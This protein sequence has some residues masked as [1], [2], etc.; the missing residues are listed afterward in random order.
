MSW[1]DD[2]TQHASRTVPA[3]VIPDMTIAHPLIHAIAHARRLQ[4]AGDA[5]LRASVQRGAQRHSGADA[6]PSRLRYD[7]YAADAGDG[8]QREAGGHGN[9]PAIEEAEVERDTAIREDGGRID[10][11]VERGRV[12]AG[13]D[14]P[15]DA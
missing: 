2:L 11:L 5:A 13:R 15:E 8:W 6:A 1:H 10:Q 3:D 4:I 9:G 12:V 7:V 14:T